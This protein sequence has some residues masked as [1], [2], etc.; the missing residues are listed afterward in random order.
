MKFSWIV[1]GERLSRMKESKMLDSLNRVL[2]FYIS[3]DPIL[4]L[5]SIG[6]GQPVV[7][8]KEDYITVKSTSSGLLIFIFTN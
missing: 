3:D 7:C 5:D 6:E 4:L 8:R 1:D 2:Y